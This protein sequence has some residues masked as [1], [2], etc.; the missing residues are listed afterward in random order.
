MILTKKLSAIDEF[1]KEAKLPKSFK[2][3]LREALK[4]STEKNGFSW[5]DKKT[6]FNEL[7]KQLRYEIALAMHQG[8]A[9]NIPFFIE[10]DPVFVS[11][12]V[13]FLHHL[14][15]TA[16]DFV[17]RA[18]EYSDEIYFLLKGK[19][20]LVFGPQS[21]IFQSV[22]KGS[23]FGDIE[24]INEIPRKYSVKA[25]VD[26]DILTMNSTLINFVKDAF[27]EI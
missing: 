16:D 23:Y 10:R 19:V 2:L 1:S 6:I 8:A 22:P 11:A 17:Y 20:S 9:T 12:I 26:S 21:K 25:L 5:A 14:F 27:P 7:P 3:K 4:Y 18:G 15:V 24:I 13:P